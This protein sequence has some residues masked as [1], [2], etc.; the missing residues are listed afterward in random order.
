[1]RAV[2]QRVSRAAVTVAGETVGTIAA[3]LCVLLSIGPDDDEAVA[4]RL[5]GRIATLRIFPDGHG[6]MN[7]DLAA[8]GGAVLVV[9][10]FTLHADTAHGHRPSFI[11]AAAPDQAARL[12]DAF[13]SSLRDLG[14]TVQ[15]G[16]FGAHMDVALVNDGPVTL[17]LT[18]GE[19]DWPA[20][21]G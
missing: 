1:M 6:R 20:D 11:R 19:P 4:R 17:V 12:C 13:V 2:V 18:S 21:A 5:A 3:G 8:K 10:Q 15:T 9:S 7:L 16:R 14:H